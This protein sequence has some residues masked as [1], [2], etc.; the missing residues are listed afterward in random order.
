MYKLRYLS[1]AQKDLE[2]ITGYITDTLK[3]PQAALEFVD[4]V[5]KELDQLREY[6]YS[7]RVYQSIKPVDTEY[8]VLKVKNYLVFYVVLDDIVE[9]HRVVYG[10]RNLAQVIK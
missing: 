4:A 2:S 10:R 1:L 5:E 8:R 6:P 3:A 9:V 7:C